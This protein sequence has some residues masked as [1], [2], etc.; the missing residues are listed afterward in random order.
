MKRTIGALLLLVTLRGFAPRPVTAVAWLSGRWVEEGKSG[1]AE[2]IWS[3]DRGGILLG[4][5]KAGK[6]DA[7][8]FWEFMRIAPGA[9][10]RLV[11]WA[12]P[13]GKEATAFPMTTAGAR[14]IVFE[15][16]KNDYPTRIAYRRTGNSLVA[17]ISGPAGANPHTWRYR[18][19]G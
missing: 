18:R 12:S 7:P 9:D 6:G 3:S 17:T 14:E 5:A 16:P 4:V 2:E 15:N 10:G 13:Q 11:F 19:K 1:W 8:Q